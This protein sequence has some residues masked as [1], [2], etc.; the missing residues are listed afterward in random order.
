MITLYDADNEAEV[1]SIT[2][3]QLSL[4]QENLVEEMLD[5]Y[6]YNI[7]AAAIAS[8]ESSGADGQ[9]EG[10]RSEQRAIARRKK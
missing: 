1:G 8:L 4:V 6:S 2:E 7:D 5:E 10:I 3:E 9:L